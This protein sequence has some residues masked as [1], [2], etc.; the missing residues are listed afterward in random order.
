VEAK[1][2]SSLAQVKREQ[3]IAISI[4]A[5]LSALQQ[6]F[7]EYIEKGN[8]K[9][10]TSSPSESVVA[11]LKIQLEEKE[12]LLQKL[13]EEVESIRQDRDSLVCAKDDMLVAHQMEHSNTLQECTKYKA[14]VST[15]EQQIQASKSEVLQLTSVKD[16]LEES[17]SKS[18]AQVMHLQES[19]ITKEKE[20]KQ[21][22]AQWKEQLATCEKDLKKEITCLKQQLSQEQAKVKD[23]ERQCIQTQEHALQQISKLAEDLKPDKGC[24]EEL[25]IAKD[26][27][28]R[29]DNT[30]SSLQHGMKQ[31]LLNK[32]TELQR[33]EHTIETCHQDLNLCLI[34]KTNAENT[35]VALQTKATNFKKQLEETES[36]LAAAE[37]KNQLLLDEKLNLSQKVEVLSDENKCSREKASSVEGAL[38]NEVGKVTQ[39]L[40]NEK[41]RSNAY[42]AK[43]VEAHEKNVKAKELLNNIAS[44]QNK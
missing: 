14:K 29:L 5:E 23:L 8:V 36:S 38:K 42:K 19:L 40:D 18:N 13:H 11:E 3:E 39:L 6:S 35:T 43:A 1:H 37:N 22:T 33:L 16:E 24:K 20:H 41:R 2:E 26:Q 32:E 15:L 30:I 12:L 4:Q 10:N 27:I 44:P 7:A 25:L 34:E 28:L 31:Q 21:S 17:L 9:T